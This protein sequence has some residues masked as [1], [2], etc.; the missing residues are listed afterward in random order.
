VGDPDAAPDI[1]TDDYAAAQEAVNERKTL[2]YLLPRA[3][4]LGARRVLDVG[5]GIGTMVR[6]FEQQGFESYGVDLPGLHRHW[7]RLGLST[8]RMFVIDPDRLQLP[9]AN[10]SID[11]VYTLGVIEHVGTTNGHSDRRPDYHAVRQQWL[12]EVF[13]VVRPGGS[14]L[15]GGPNRGFPVDA[16]HDLDTRASALERWLS[17]RVGLSVHRTWGEYFLWNH[18]D[19][20]RYLDGLPHELL[21]QSVDGFLSFG[22][23]RGAMQGL[24]TVYARHLPRAL[25]GTG[26][27]PWVMALV[28]KPPSANAGAAG[29]G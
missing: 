11:F 21:P 4:A 25:W 18:A 10:N 2:D 9:F 28:S 1:T 16:A 15:V 3:R 29:R 19:V 20:R 24:A 27:N 14:M 23:A 13:R 6:T 22:R 12:R 5:C 7:Q 17:R 26:F 8:E